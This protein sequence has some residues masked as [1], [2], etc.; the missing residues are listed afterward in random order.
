M[1]QEAKQRLIE[2]AIKTGDAIKQLDDNLAFKRV[3]L[4][5]KAALFEEFKSSKWWS[6][7]AWAGIWSRL[8]AIDGIEKR[9]QR[10]RLEEQSA[11]EELKK[12]SAK[13]ES[14]MRRVFR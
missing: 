12:M 9:L 11:R 1:N 4:E 3:M 5:E 13:A 8:K 2:S 10:Y 7:I 14:P 6:F